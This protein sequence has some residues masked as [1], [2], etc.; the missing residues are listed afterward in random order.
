MLAI[1]GASIGVL[2]RRAG[3]DPSATQPAVRDGARY[4]PG[5]ILVRFRR[6]ATAAQRAGAHA[7][8]DGSVERT[9][10]T[11]PQLQLVQLPGGITVEEGLER[12]RSLPDVLYAEPDYQVHALDTPNDPR[13]VEQWAL[14]NAGQAFATVAGADIGATSAWAITR[15]SRQVVVAVVDAGVDYKH[16]D[17][18]GNLFRN[19]VDCTPNGVDDDHNGYIDDCYGIDTFNHD[20]DPFDDNF[21]GTHVSGTIGARG[22]NGIGVAGVNW[23]VSIVACKFLNAGGGG[24]VSGAVECLDYLGKLADSGVPIVA[25]SHSWGGGG[26]SQALVDAVAGQLNRGI[27]FIVA[28]G[29]DASDNDRFGASPSDIFLPNVISVAATT[30][31]DGLARFSNYGRRTVHLGAPGQSILSTTPGDTYSYMSGTSMATPHVTGVAAL[32]KAQDPTRDWRAIRNLLLSG[33]DRTLPGLVLS[34]R[35]LSAA[36]SLQCTTAT[37]Q[38]RIRPVGAT[39][40]GHAGIPVP[41]AALHATCAAPAGNVTVTVE[42]GGPSIVLRDDGQAPDQASGDGTYTGQFLSQVAGTYT[43]NFG[44]GDQVTVTVLPSTYRAQVGDEPPRVIAGT[45]LELGNQTFARLV[46]PFPVHF[47]GGTFNALYVGDNGVLSFEHSSMSELPPSYGTLPVNAATTLIAPFWMDLYPSPNTAQN[48]YWAVQGT[49]PSRELVIEWRDLT[50]AA[51]CGDDTINTV[52]FQVVLSESTDDVLFT[53]ADTV[54][55]GLCTAEDAGGSATIGVQVG[56]VRAAVFGL[57]Q[58]V[59]HDGMSLRWTTTSEVTGIAGTVAERA[60]GNALAGIRVSLYDVAGSFVAE[61]ASSWAGQFRLEGLAAGTYYAKTSNSVGYVDRIYDDIPCLGCGVTSGQPIVTV[62][63]QVRT[64]IDFALAKGGAIAGTVTDAG[65]GTG[66]SG[67][68]VAVY[69]GAGGWVAAAATSSTGDYTL[70]GLGAGTY[71]VATWNSLGYIDEIYDDLTLAG[72]TVVEGRAIV[73]AATQTVSGINLALAKGGSVT[74]SVTDAGSGAALTGVSVGLY[75]SRGT[76]LNNAATSSGGR[77]TIGG[78][79]PGTYYAKTYNTQGYTDQLYDN[80]PCVNCVI[81]TGQPIVV[82]ATQ[83]VSGINFALSKGGAIAGRV[84]DEASGNG[85]AGVLINIYSSGGTFVGWAQT[86]AGGSYS[87]GGLLPGTYNVKTSNTLGYIDELYDNLPCLGCTATTGKPIVVG[88]AQTVSGINFALAKGGAIAGTVTETGTGAALVGVSITVYSSSGSWVA[89]TETSAG[90]SYKVGG[91]RTGTYYA[92]TGNSLGYTNQ[93][94]DNV[95]CVACAVATGRPIVVVGTQ[96]ISGINFA[97]S[98]GGAIA[99]S[100]TAA[101][102]GASLVGVW[103]N[104]YTSAGLWVSGTQTSAGG[105]YTLGGLIPGAYYVSTY[106]TLGYVDEVYDNLPCVGCSILSGTPIVVTGTQTVSGINFALA[107][108]SSA[109]GSGVASGAGTA[110]VSVSGTTVPYAANRILVRFKPGTGG[111]RR[112]GAREATGAIVARTYASVPGLELLELPSALG[113]A[114]TLARYRARSD[115]LYAEPDY[116]VH[117]LEVP[118]DPRFGEQWA[119]RNTGQFLRSVAG[120]DINAPGAW[121]F[122]RGSHQVVV[123]VIDT[124]VDYRHPDLLGNLFRNEAECTANGLDDDHNGYIDDCYGIDTFNHDSDPFDDHYHGTHVS[125]TIGARGDNGLGVAGVNWAV[126]IVAC[127]F[128]SG[129]GSGYT[130]GAVECLD[131]LAKLADSGVPIVA[132]NNSWGGGGF[133]QALLDAIAG[134]MSRGILFIA[135]AGN[136]GSNNDSIPAYPANYFLPNVLSVAAT[137]SADVRARFSSY[138]RRTVHLAAPGQNILSTLPDDSYGSLSGTS[139]ATPHVTG[140]AA[141]LKAQDP[142]RDWRAIRNLLLTGGDA[143]PALETVTGRRLNAAAALA[144]NHST[145][146]ARIQPTE[147]SL[148]GNV[149]VPIPLTAVHVTCADPAGDVNVAVSPGGE[150]VVLHDT[151]QSPDQV[152]GD[153]TYA[154]EFVPHAPGT[155]TLTFSGGDVV[156]VQVLASTYQAHVASEAYRVIVGTSLDVED[157]SWAKLTTPF[158]VLFGGGTFGA[159]WVSDDGMVSFGRPGPRALQPSGSLPDAGVMTLVAPMRMDLYPTPNT[160]QTV[161]WEVLGAAPARELVIEWRDL[162]AYSSCGDDI[163]DTVRFQLVL[164]EN[165]DDVVFAYADTTFGGFCSWA[166]GGA[167]ATVGIQVGST[168]AAQFSTNGT[169]LSA[170]MTL[171]WTTTSQVTSLVGTVTDATTGGPLADV[172]VSVH[173][174]DGAAVATAITSP[175]G[176]YRVEGLAAGTYYAKTSNG[177][178]YI[179]ELYDNVPCSGCVVTTGKPIVVLAAQ[180]VSGIDF[181]LL[182]VD[183]PTQPSVTSH[184]QDQSVSAGAAAT[185]T[186]AAGG[187]PTPAVQWQVT[188]N[189]GS[190]WVNLPGATSTALSFTTVV[191]D[192]G[193]RFRAMFSSSAGSATTNAATLVVHGPLSASPSTLLFGATKAASSATLSSQT[194]AQAVTV[195]FGGAASS[196]TVSSSDTWIAITGGSGTA[197]G[198]FTVGIRNPSDVIGT[199]MSLSGTVTITSVSA[200]N[201]PVSV[202]VTLRVSRPGASAPPLGAFDTPLNQAVGLQG[203]FAVTGWALD[204]VGIDRVELWRDPVAGETTPTYYGPGQPGHGRIFIANPLFITGSRADV[205]GL[206]PNYPFANRAGWGYLLLSWGLWNQGN[207]TYTLHAFAFDAEGNST[208]LGTKTISVDNAHATKPFGAL[209]TPGYG[210]T[211]SGAFWNYGWALT[212][213]ATPACAITNGSVMMT[214]DSGPPLVVNYGDRRSDIAASFPGFSNENTSGGAYYIDTTTLTNGMHQIGWL[215]YDSCGRGDGIG[216]RFFTVLN[217]TGDA[218]QPGETPGLETRPTPMPEDARI[219]VGRVSRPGDQARSTITVR[220]LGGE[221]EGVQP[222]GDGRHVVEIIQ[223]G[224]IEIQ[225]PLLLEGAYEVSHEVQGQ[226]RP[227]PLGSSFDAANGAFYWQPAPAFLGTFDLTFDVPGREAV[228]VRIVV[229]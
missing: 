34:G 180:T 169:A 20:S 141:L 17:L 22:D 1:A 70:S 4:A 13:F 98:K 102:T 64:G 191:G 142:T 100:V 96:T 219:D 54:F 190:T 57:G 202:P 31:A 65:T 44:G 156:T 184:P 122:T 53:Y 88:A 24:Y 178:G 163:R 62:A 11:V 81:A 222:D 56:G 140:V 106:N 139:M 78:L 120:A 125:G 74:G 52:R 221:W 27:L 127:K 85:V 130:S 193:K 129:G 87:V 179:D 138:G 41:L 95:T 47:G 162:T 25:S 37:V 69:N 42:P 150:T 33:G 60:T 77:Y 67:V 84:T 208:T 8:A 198:A 49:A 176:Q 63:G 154:G 89:G 99:G 128:L 18:Q 107:T 73:V 210:E 212:P 145:V 59:L 175:A 134:Q 97:L 215:V 36:G 165:S 187:K 6:D 79:L 189:G 92:R 227:L 228:R 2:A 197:A 9:Y 166:D 90:G 35:R 119:L 168:R 209:D 82:S 181:A 111:V 109:I 39:V 167:S 28:A 32:L 116:E 206:Y 16:P 46:A 45:S 224:R 121:A 48:V 174:A 83:T 23:S 199:S 136:A 51:P 152:A 201:S 103:L 30:S 118:S 164:F 158:P 66:L 72:R 68:S 153:G 182:A 117:A 223:G 159:I 104:L 91:L 204:D 149:G 173:G 188:A 29:N 194:A 3:Q 86:S 170:G 105:S 143:R 229:K 186:A 61:S 71:Y 177:L 183:P 217:A 123:A 218:D 161:Y 144:C 213:H 137:T 93:L 76:P 135:A 21:H 110:P 132:S 211:K 80:L 157:N 43:L 19:E 38:E 5:R 94:Y 55:G 40:T 15:G 195:A 196:W 185:F 192:H 75:T 115:V 12:Y 148:V 220:Q 172:Q 160:T 26:F 112:E 124:G 216:S 14:R 126:S 50:A 147:S 7:A 214:I 207:G 171:R 203:S 205:E 58:A 226:R 131:Y 155:Y 133:S 200:S 113:L 225:L 114:E 146:Q 151:G 101:S 10:A 108:G